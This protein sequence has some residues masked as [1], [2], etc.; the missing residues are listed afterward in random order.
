MI[1]MYPYPQQQQQQ[2][3]HSLYPISIVVVVVVY[4]YMDLFNKK[5]LYRTC[6]D[7]NSFSSVYDTP[8]WSA[9]KNAVYKLYT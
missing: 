2:R 6:C 8:L 5:D 7:L 9:I 4:I 3:Q 1:K